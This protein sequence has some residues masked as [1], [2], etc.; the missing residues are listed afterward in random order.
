MTVPGFTAELTLSNSHGS[1]SSRP[2]SLTTSATDRVEPAGFIDFWQCRGVCQGLG[3]S[4]TFC[5]TIC[6]PALLF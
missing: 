5:N 6:S 2:A 1:P 4:M 3:G